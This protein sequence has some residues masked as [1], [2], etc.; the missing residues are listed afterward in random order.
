MTPG[1]FFLSTGSFHSQATHRATSER[2]SAKEYKRKRPLLSRKR[3][4]RFW[5]K[6]RASMAKKVKMKR[7][8][9][10]PSVTRY[11]E[12]ENRGGGEVGAMATPSLASS[13]T[14]S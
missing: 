1:Y 8:K 7:M 4:L 13:W 2:V 14:K 5:C 6:T 11:L 9:I 10:W 12:K 3:R